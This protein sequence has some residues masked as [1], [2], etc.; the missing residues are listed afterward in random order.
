MGRLSSLQYSPAGWQAA[1]PGEGTH[2]M[3]SLK[4]LAFTPGSWALKVSVEGPRRGGVG[5]RAGLHS[6]AQEGWAYAERQAGIQGV[7][8]GRQGCR[9]AGRQA[10]HDRN[11]RTSIA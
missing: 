1:W 4:E 11:A 5:A 3:V 2:H 6:T 9:D 8:G 7:Q 10:E